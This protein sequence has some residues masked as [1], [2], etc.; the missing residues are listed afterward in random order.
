MRRVCLVALF[1]LACHKGE[2]SAQG[3]GGGVPVTVAK[4]QQKNVPLN[5]RAIGNV[6]PITSVTVRPQVGG[7]LLKV[8]FKEGQEVKKGDLLFE[9]D[10]RPLQAQLLQAQAMLARDEANARDAAA[11]ARRYAALVKKEYVTQQQAD[12]AEAQAQALKA[13]LAADQAAV[14][15]ARLNLAYAQ[16]RAPVSG[17]TGSL[18]VHAGNVVKATDDKLV[19]IDQVQPIYVS[20]SVPEQMLTQIRARAGASRLAVTAAP[21]LQDNSGA[22]EQKAGGAI[23]GERHTGVLTFVDNAVDQTTGQIR[24]KATF[25]NE[26]EALWPG[27]FVDVQLTLA[28]QQGAVVAPVEAVQRGQNGEYVFVVKQDGTVESREVVVSRADQHDAIIEKGLAPG[29]TVVTD[30]QLRLQQGVKVQIKGEAGS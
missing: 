30:G 23:G 3:G 15:Q 20:F 1:A 11:T 22:P 16:I 14:Q 2:A 24:L 13:A 12:N 6:E 21:A 17:R 29:E 9:I 7:V 19:V 5:V 27:Q 4:V 8:N 10:Q 25:A 26:D 28:E 18:L